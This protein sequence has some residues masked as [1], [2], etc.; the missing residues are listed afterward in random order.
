MSRYGNDEDKSE[1]ISK[2]ASLLDDQVGKIRQL[3]SELEFDTLFSF[4][5][6]KTAHSR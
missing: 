5:K 4:S 6:R 3:K 2:A 1:A